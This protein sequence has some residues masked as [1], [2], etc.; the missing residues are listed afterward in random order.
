MQHIGEGSAATGMMRK[1]GEKEL[2]K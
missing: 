1:F 2:V